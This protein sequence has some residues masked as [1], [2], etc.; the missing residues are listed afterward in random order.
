MAAPDASSDHFSWPLASVVAIPA[1][2]TPATAPVKTAVSE[3]SVL[4]SPR[5]TKASPVARSSARRRMVRSSLARTPP[6]ASRDVVIKCAATTFTTSP[7]SRRRSRARSALRRSA[8]GMALK[9]PSLSTHSS[10]STFHAAPRSESPH[11]SRNT[12]NPAA[13]AAAPSAG[14]SSNLFRR[15][16]NAR[17]LGGSRSSRGSEAKMPSKPAARIAEANVSRFAPSYAA[18]ASWQSYSR[19]TATS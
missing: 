18:T 16:N 5:H 14:A 8:A 9:T 15:Q 4:K 3:G 6:P 2:S 10:R 13:A 19:R 1:S 11:A 17:P 12:P 7:V